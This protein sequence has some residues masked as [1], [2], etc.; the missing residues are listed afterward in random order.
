MQCV[1]KPSRLKLEIRLY[2]FVNRYIYCPH[3]N[4]TTH[5]H[6]QLL[7]AIFPFFY[8][9]SLT[10]LS[11][12]RPD[13]AGAKQ[14]LGDANFLRRLTDYDKDNIK[15]QILLKLQK[16]INNPDFIPEKVCLDFMSNTL[17]CQ[18]DLLVGLRVNRLWPN[19]SSKTFWKFGKRQSW[20][21]NSS[22]I[23]EVLI[24]ALSTYVC[25]WN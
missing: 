14:V 9:S 1:S 23:A 17:I 7:L 18:S 3:K 21:E 11:S 15:P 19:W 20:V 8:N 5:A 16:Y 22:V 6:T 10:P 24:M 2:H 25:W 4:G 12:Y 13:W